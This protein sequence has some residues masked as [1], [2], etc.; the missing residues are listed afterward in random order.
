MADCGGIPIKK[1]R[2]H[3]TTHF[4]I[5]MSGNSLGSFR[6]SGWALKLRKWW[7]FFLT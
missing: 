5:F 3:D 1:L 7:M 2:L 6:I 4:G